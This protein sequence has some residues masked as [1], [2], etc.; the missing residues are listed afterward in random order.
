MPESPQTNEL[1]HERNVLQREHTR[2]LEVIHKARQ[3]A[4]GEAIQSAACRQPIPQEKIDHWQATIKQT[5]TELMSVQEKIGALNQRLRALRANPRPD[6]RETQRQ[7]RETVYLSCFYQI[8]KESLDPKLLAA[9]E[10]D[11][12]QL[13]HDH[14]V[15]HQ[16]PS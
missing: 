12:R 9:I 4:R 16:E 10:R 7:E 15:M 5:Q 13:A 3:E 11:A 2:L 14:Q 8:A 1:L 6:Y